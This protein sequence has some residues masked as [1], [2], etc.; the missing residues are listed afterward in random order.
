MC[1]N[2]PEG[3]Q[4]GTHT[5]KGTAYSTHEEP[6]RS[7]VHTHKHKQ[8]CMHPV[9]SY[10]GEGA[11]PLWSG[12]RTLDALCWPDFLRRAAVRRTCQEIADDGRR[13]SLL[14]KAHH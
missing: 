14:H 7:R 10:L 1:V 9:K 6:T 3:C 2:E 11:T 13:R 12:D 4:H 5:N 8:T